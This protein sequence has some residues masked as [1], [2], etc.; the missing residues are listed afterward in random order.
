MVSE[1]DGRVEPGTSCRSRGYREEGRSPPPNPDPKEA[2]SVG[3]RVWSWTPFFFSTFQ[4]K[5][6]DMNMDRARAITFFLL[7]VVS[8]LLFLQAGGMKIFDW[9]GGVPS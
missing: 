6:E 7:R 8:G 9:F 2:N 5:G 1:A 4:Q 3:A